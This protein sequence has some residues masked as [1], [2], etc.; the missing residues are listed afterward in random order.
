MKVKVTERKLESETN[1][2]NREVV[3]VS[4][5]KTKSPKKEKELHSVKHSDRQ[6]DRKEDE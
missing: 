6:T 4:R 5:D 3:C 2:F 1:F